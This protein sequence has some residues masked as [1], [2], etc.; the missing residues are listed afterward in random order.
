[1][2]GPL[3]NDYVERA[4]N[5]LRIQRKRSM[6]FSD[7]LV[8]DNPAWELL[9]EIYIAT[10]QDNWI[11]KKALNESLSAPSSIISRWIDV[12]ADRK[13]LVSCVKNDQ[14]YVQLTDSARG[15]CHAYLD[16]IA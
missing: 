6:F 4:Q 14:D 9:L 10:E 7:N 12:F 16:A 2:T 11:S 1:M 5:S 3:L 15:Q 8:F 13:Y